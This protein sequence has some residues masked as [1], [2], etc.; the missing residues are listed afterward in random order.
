MTDRDSGGAPSDPREGSSSD[1]EADG[2]PEAE[3]RRLLGVADESPSTVGQLMTELVNAM[4]EDRHGGAA[5]TDELGDELRRLR[6]EVHDARRELV[7]IAD[8][9]ERLADALEE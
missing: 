3:V 8:A 6:D 7:R 2:V 4:A 9:T 1:G 5:D